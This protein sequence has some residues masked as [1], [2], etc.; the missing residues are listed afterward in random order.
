MADSLP[1]VDDIKTNI[2]GRLSRL[3][4]NY[5]DDLA[6][7][8]RKAKQ[9]LKAA[10]LEMV[11]MHRKK[12][13]KLEATQQERWQ[14]EELKRSSRIRKGFKGLWDKINGR[15]WKTRKRNEQE[16]WQAH[17]RDQKER[18]ALI[19]QQL[20]QR[21]NLQVQ[22]NL[23]REKQDKE[24]KDLFRDLSQFT[25]QEQA[26]GNE[27]LE[28]NWLHDLEFDQRGEFEREFDNDLDIDDPDID[29]EPEL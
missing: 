5:T 24:R 26:K 6:R 8:H 27:A 13:A 16:T 11:T 22:I 12:R 10:K 15:Y 7:E 3:F 9:P 17:K 18:E 29:M 20:T 14:A 19:H 28:K 4:R 21:Q 2:H 23:L 25:L 1:S